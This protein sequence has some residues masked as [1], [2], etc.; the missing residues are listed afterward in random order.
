MRMRADVPWSVSAINVPLNPVPTI[1]ISVL[2]FFFIIL[3]PVELITKKLINTTALSIPSNYQLTSYPVSCIVYLESHINCLTEGNIYPTHHPPVP[4]IRI[5]RSLQ[6]DRGSQ[7][8]PAPVLHV[9][10]WREHLGYQNVS[11][12]LAVSL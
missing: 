2:I 1:Q 10:I 6:V 7:D 3:Y 12:G 4:S 9:S 5:H 11:Q 8:I